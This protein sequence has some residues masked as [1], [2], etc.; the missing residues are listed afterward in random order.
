MREPVRNIGASVRDRLLNIARERKQSLDLLLTRYVLERLLYR[1]STTNHRDRFVLKGAMLLATWFD[2]PLRPTRDLDL[3]SFGDSDPEA[4]LGVFGEICA[5]EAEDG[6]VF[7]V[8]ALTVDH[9]RETLAD[10]G[11]RIKTNAA[12]GGA[13]V[14][15]VI[16]IGF[17]D[18]VEPGI[19]ETELPVLLDL[20][21]P[22]LR[23]YPREAVIA[24][25]FQAM[26]VLGRANSRMKD[27]YDIWALSR[28]YEFKG[29]ALARA[30]AATFA[31]RNTVIPAEPPIA[32]T[33]A[34]A[35]MPAKQQ[36]WVSFVDELA[37]EPGR[38][39]TIIRDLAEF[40]MPHAVVA[41]TLTDSEQHR[42]D[43]ISR[44]HDER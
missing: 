27:L 38:L 3:L 33:R 26:V 19:A 42:S 40:L 25:K 17:G 7:D 8:A 22:R 23:A 37:V 6:V 35:E 5:V 31:R 11:L 12:V 10:G 14:R 39:D 13:R 43:D 30:I 2:S 34:F 16:D 21:P 18:A 44:G 1:L 28:A 4:M 20:P 9:V 41:L 32:L 36:Q 15:V 29:D 24:E